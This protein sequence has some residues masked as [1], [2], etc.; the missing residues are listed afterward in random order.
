MHVV[1]NLVCINMMLSMSKF[2]RETLLDE[3]FTYLFNRYNNSWAPSRHNTMP[4]DKRAQYGIN[5][6]AKCSHVRTDRLHA[7]VVCVHGICRHMVCAQ[8]FYRHLAGGFK[9]LTWATCCLHSSTPWLCVYAPV[10]PE[11][12][13]SRYSLALF[14]TSGGKSF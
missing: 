3:K 2:R 12:V 7:K 11:P 10:P 9:G 14:S 1:Y 6:D 13:A 4:L 8:D 5:S